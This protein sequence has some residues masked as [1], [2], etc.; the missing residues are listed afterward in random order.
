MFV[1]FA[2]LVRA[3]CFLLLGSLL[4][5]LPRSA[6][7][8]TNV[9]VRVM[10][11]N[12][13]GNAQ[14]YQPFALRIF[15]GLKPDIVAIQEFNYS[16]NTPADFRSMLDTAFGTDFVYFREA[17]TG[18]GDIP[19]GIISRYPILAAG[20]WTDTVQ[21]QPNRGFAWAQIDL[22]GTNALYV[23]SVHLL[24]SSATARASEAAN[25]KTLIQTAFPSNAWIVVAG[26][27][28][29]DSR[30]E[31]AIATFDSFLSD[32]PIPTD[33]VSGG[34][35]NTSLNRNHPHDYVLPSFSFTNLMA[36]AVFPSHS[37]ANGLVFDSRVYTPLSDVAPVELDDS[38]NA[39]HMAVLKDFQFTLSVTNSSTNAPAITTPPQSQTVNLG[40]NATFTVVATGA[41]PLAY[42]WLFNDTAIDAATNSAYTRTN[43]QSAHAGNYTVTVTNSL[44][45]VTSAPAAVLNV[46]AGPVIATPPQSQTV[47]A[48]QN[49]PFS[50]SVTGATPVAYQWR[51]NG[52][53]LANATASS[54]TRTNAQPADA[55]SY[56][57]VITNTYGAITSLNAALTVTTTQGPVIAQWDFNSP[58]PDGN[59]ATGTT[60]PSLGTG[61][62]SLIGG[63]TQAFAGGSST[64]PAPSSDNSGWNTTTYPASGAS[65]KTAGVQFNVST[66]GRQ[67]ISIRWDHRV[68]NTG[69]K[70]ARLRYTT[71]GTTFVDYPAA[72]VETAGAIFEPKTNSLAGLPGVDNN[73]LFAFQ[74]V[75]EFQNTATGSGSAA[76]YAV[77]GTYATT[78]TTRFDMVTVSG[79]AIPPAN[80]PAPP[81]LSAS[82]LDTNRSFQF[83]LSGTAGSNY[84]VQASTNLS[85]SDWVSLLTNAAPFGFVDANAG[86]FPQ[87]FYRALAAP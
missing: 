7:A 73:P 54:F 33:A 75:A 41:A 22:P 70:Y 21:T 42:Q 68:S 30:S 5:F 79:T 36:A 2:A 44:G 48:G 43:A 59:T 18:S 87:R 9:T 55:G 8:Q 64:D 82:A 69:S 84:I 71:N 1:R 16:N 6:P 76:Y 4:V 28:N 77:N 31:T 50:V 14:T 60:A 32:N 65:N 34:N 56:S 52:T 37:F 67:N 40:S 3:G 29:T 23:V 38:T 83:T 35:S 26:D 17:F 45:S 13:N 74:I 72:T 63:T 39:Q 27:L 47:A 24:T 81:L 58:T 19:N 78:G 51:F 10:A 15:Q 25:L 61:T 62:A 49:A 66:A 11:A 86:L 20:S 12:L 85:A 53:N 57:V 80:P 46:Y